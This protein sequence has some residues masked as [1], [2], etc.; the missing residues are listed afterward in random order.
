MEKHQ[1]I[2][3]F[4]NGTIGDTAI[5]IPSFKLIKQSFPLSEIKVLTLS[6]KENSPVMDLLL[7][8]S[9]LVDGYIYYQ[10]VESSRFRDF[11]EM[12]RKVK[13]WNPD[14]VIYLVEIQSI[15]TVIRDKVFFRSCGIKKVIG[16]TLQYSLFKK[17]YIERRGMYEHESEHLLRRIS[18]LGVIDIDSLESWDIGLSKENNALQMKPNLEK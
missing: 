16:L 17:K 2:L 18:E 9:G 1:K 5:A 7:K 4:R 6:N 12:R 14:V 15:Y 13:E 8:G 3:I 11:I 10:N